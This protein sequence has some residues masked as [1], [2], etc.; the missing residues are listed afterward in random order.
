MLLLL[1]P[2][3]VRKMH[4]VTSLSAWQWTLLQLSG[5]LCTADGLHV[6]CLGISVNMGIF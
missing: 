2:I 4:V 1:L 5:L 3:W 6:L